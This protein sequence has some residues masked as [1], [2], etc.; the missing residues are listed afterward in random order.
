MQPSTEGPV[1]RSILWIH[2]ATQVALAAVF[3]GLCTAAVVWWAPEGWGMIRM[4]AAGALAG[5]SSYYCLFN[6]RIIVTY[7]G[8]L[9]DGGGAER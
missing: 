2:P 7:F 5:L 8:D 3:V 9:P 4:M 1:Q 6:N